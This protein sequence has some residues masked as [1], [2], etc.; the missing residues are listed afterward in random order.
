M[1][2]SCTPWPFRTRTQLVSWRLTESRSKKMYKKRMH[3]ECISL[4]P[5]Q[6]LRQIFTGWT[7]HLCNHL[8]IYHLIIFFLISKYFSTFNFNFQASSY[9]FPRRIIR[10]FHRS[11]LNFDFSDNTARLLFT[12]DSCLNEKFLQWETALIPR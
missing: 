3:A 11:F 9:I 4:P 5:S 8:V 1:V 6:N 7:R 10:V 2:L 12:R